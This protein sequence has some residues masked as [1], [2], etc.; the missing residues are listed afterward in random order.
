MGNKYASKAEEK[1][2]EDNI[3][4]I[5]CF[6]D[7]LTAGYLNG[8]SMHIPYSNTLQE[9]IEKEYQQSFKS[10]VIESGWDGE[11][12]TYSMLTRLTSVLKHNPFDFVIFL[13]GTNDVG[14]AQKAQKI[15]EELKKIYNVIMVQNK[16]KCI[17]LTIPPYGSVLDQHNNGLFGDTRAKVNG[18]IRAQVEKPNNNQMILCDL[19][20]HIH[21]L[22]DGSKQKFFDKD[23]L[24]FS[25]YGYTQ[26]G[27][28]VFKT[29]VPL[30]DEMKRNHL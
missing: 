16:A 4:R 14:T 13:G 8:G 26:M 29:M 15:C 12:L 22:D 9:L 20:D 23:G 10:Q 7:S 25:E 17:A 19:Y 24:H 21:S 5:L 27:Q 30:L 11:K 3:V 2:N 6:G 1:S 28:L 18:F